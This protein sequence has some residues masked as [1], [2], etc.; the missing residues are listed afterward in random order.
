MESMR[1]FLFLLFI[2]PLLWGQLY[3]PEYHGIDQLLFLSNRYLIVAVVDIPEVVEK[4]NELSLGE[5]VKKAELVKKN[6]A[7]WDAKKVAESLFDTY[8]AKARL[9]AGE[10]NMDSPDFYTIT[11]KDDP[12]Y[13]TA[14]HPARST[15]TIVSLNKGEVLGGP[16]IHYAHY[17]YLEMPDALL[18]GKTYTIALSNG[19]GV[20]FR[21]DETELVSRAIKVNQEGYLKDAPKKYAYLGA[22]L[23]EFG[24]HDF[25]FAPTFFVLEAETKKVV[26]QGEIKLRSENIRITPK[27]T[28]KVEEKPFITGE[29]V[30]ELDL[31]PLETEGDFFISIP[32][33]GRSW[34]FRHAGDTY[35]QVFYVAARSLYHQRCGILIGKP[36]SA[37]P[38][39]ACH[40][41]PVYESEAL[42]FAPSISPPNGYDPFDVIGATL[43]KNRATL[44]ARGGWHDAA[45][46]DRN[47]FHYTNILDLLFA[48]EL[49]PD[50]FY[51][52]QLNIPESGNGVPDIL[53]EAEFGLRV[54]RKSQSKEGGV[55]GMVETF[56]HPSINDPD[57]PYAFSRRTRWSSLIYAGA[58]AQFAE[59]VR[60]FS[61]ERALLYT[62]SALA[63][64]Q[65][66]IDPKNFLGK[67]VI[68]AKKNR[69][70]GEPYTVEWEEKDE[71]NY[72]F[73]LFA[74]LR[75]FLLTEDERFLEG[76]AP[77]LQTSL[78]PYQHPFS[79]KD[80]S[81]WLFFPIVY[82]RLNGHIPELIRLSYKKLYYDA[83][84]EKKDLSEKAPYRESWPL[85]QDY[86]LGWGAN[87]MTNQA[88]QLYL[89][90]IV[91]DE[92]ALRNAALF[93]VDFMLGCNPMGMSWVTGLGFVY[94]VSIQHAVSENDG[95]ADP[96]PGLGIYG[97]TGGTF[98][99]LRQTIWQAKD[100]KGE[101]ISFQ[102]EANKE[103]PLF[104][105][106]SAHPH[107]NVAQDEFTIHETNSS[108]IFTAACLMPTGWMPSEQL[109]NKEP[110][111]KEFLYGYW[112]LP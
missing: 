54:W 42:P 44:D 3:Q 22:Y 58:A 56:A 80:F 23:Q 27:V 59:L 20:T 68:H 47:I 51:D 86:W 39:I 32:G 30:Y 15:R 26:F 57:F 8:F 66:G 81:P 89:G 16:D 112:Y 84:L 50:K 38:R 69:G 75:L 65:F 73:L 1:A 103:I 37:W 93:N 107:D 7:D 4:I 55:S 109:K 11:S 63:A 77:L 61:K 6:P 24:A 98:Y 12:R 40:E 29:K 97:I 72:P 25:S 111:E 43:D 82:D 76:I 106:W 96:V 28:E 78:K 21:F 48:Y 41:G 62:K 35:G 14:L 105:R 108:L 17:V 19:K 49:Y 53:D 46:W 92:K 2:E 100:E 34:P 79:V 31:T 52:G 36:Y 90:Y 110:R 99:N 9:L 70:A 88:R 60:P 10:K 5:Y 67:V 13:K 71:F 18:S 102:P 87:F 101:Y 95:I 104:R 33:V 85:N 74:K 91:S 45:D 83:A 64:Y 94:P